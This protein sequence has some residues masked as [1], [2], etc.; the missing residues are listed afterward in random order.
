MPHARASPGAVL[1]TVSFE[2]ILMN[3]LA[4]K[5]PL[6]EQAIDTGLTRS[7]RKRRDPARFTDY[8][9]TSAVPPQLSRQFLTKKRQLEAAKARAAATLQNENDLEPPP[10][11]YSDEDSSVDSEV[12]QQITTTPDSFGVF[13]KYSSIPSHNP[14]D[15]DP[16]DNL[17]SIPPR[18]D[19]ASI[20]SDLNISSARHNSNPLA[21]SKNP[22]EDLLLGWWSEGSCDGIASLDRLVKCLTS[23]HFDPSQL[24]DFSAV[25]AVRRFEKQHCSSN[26]GTTLEPGDGWKVGSVKIRLPCTKVKQHEEDAP[27]FTVDG[28]LYRDVA[29]VITKELQDPDSFERLH[30]KPFEEWW[31]P[32]GSDDPVRV[33]SDVYT[34]DAMLEADRKLQESLK[35]TGSA[36]PH[37]ETFIVSVGLYSDSTNLTAFSHASLWPMYMYIANESKYSRAKPTSFSAHHIA[38]LPTVQNLVVYLSFVVFLT[39]FPQLPDSI[40]EF[41]HECYGVYPTADMLAHLKRELIHASLRLIFRGSFADAQNNGRITRCADDIVR[42]WLLQL[43]FH[44]ADY[45]EK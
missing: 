17:P 5:V 18:I 13:R 26:P 30:L 3:L 32:S 28:I 42:R 33:Y 36:G 37:L 40:K 7:A 4:T 41:Y 6:L 11:E 12:P 44:S 22:T 2:F 8:I 15:I 24:K 27:E 20:G 38:Y 43:I 23:P 9:P 39:F 35:V 31:K 16:F 19:P 21:D 14:D 25:S 1:Q 10:G 45:I 34:S 29:E